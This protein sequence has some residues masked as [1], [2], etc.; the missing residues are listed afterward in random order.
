ML[1]LRIDKHLPVDSDA[2]L[3]VGASL[4]HQLHPAVLCPANIL[5]K[6]WRQIILSDQQIHGAIACEVERDYAPRVAEHDFVESSFRGDVSKA[7]GT[8]IAQERYPAF[9]GKIFPYGNQIDPAVVVIVQRSHS[10]ASHPS[11]V[12]KRN[13]LKGFPS[14]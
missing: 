13:R 12:R 10:P 8:F 3:A 5:Q 14:N 11:R 6:F 9:A 2:R 1:L 7:V 4:K